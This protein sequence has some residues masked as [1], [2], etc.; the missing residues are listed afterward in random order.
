MSGL[1][2]K[3]NN[4]LQGHELNNVSNNIHHPHNNYNNYNTKY[5]IKN[6]RVII[7]YSSIGKRSQPRLKLG[8]LPKNPIPGLS[9]VV[10]SFETDANID[11]K[12]FPDPQLLFAF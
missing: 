11:S 6:I 1:V 4:K 7:S 8:I 9:L 5:I 3:I 10:L 2:C 12:L